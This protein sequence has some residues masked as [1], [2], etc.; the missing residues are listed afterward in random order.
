MTHHADKLVPAAT[1]SEADVAIA[2]AR[3]CAGCGMSSVSIAGAV[4]AE[5]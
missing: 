2:A 5:S 3:A 1:T 4:A